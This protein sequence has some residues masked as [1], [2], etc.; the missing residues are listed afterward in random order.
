MPQNGAFIVTYALQAA[1]VAAALLFIV[2]SA[3]MNAL[4]LSSLG[5]SP[6]EI[7]LL[8]AVS[9]AADLA[10]ATLP[11]LVARAILLRAWGYAA[12]SALM[13]LFV[14][15]Q[16]LASGTGFIAMT[17]GAAT[18]MHEARSEQ[19]A[20]RRKELVDVEA[21][22][23]GLGAGQPVELIE[24]DLATAK[25]D[26]RWTTS[27]SCTEV[28]SAAVRQYCGEVLRLYR[29]GRHEELHRRAVEERRQLAANI[30]A[31]Q[32]GGAERTSDHQVAAIAALFGVAREIPRVILTSS[33]AVTLELG[34]IFLVLLAAGPMLRGWREP[35]SE[36]PPE[37]IPA[38]L[39]PQA[40]RSHW[41]RQRRGAT[42]GAVTERIVDHGG[43]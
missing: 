31:L 37:P 41:Q 27:K 4:F 32:V 21:E 40:D 29:L 26:R 19:L 25:L 2:V 42:F 8:A 17:R 1:V 35:G 12:V 11:V 15:L 23:A 7:G 20:Q 36:P 30:E 13:L 43:K 14:V 10:K 18:S 33:V 22:I 16:S 6:I 9:L 24:A 5:R 28:V 39:P 3:T 34:S 38:P